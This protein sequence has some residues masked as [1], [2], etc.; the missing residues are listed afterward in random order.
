MDIELLDFLGWIRPPDK[1]VYWKIVFFITHPKHMLW[2]L[3]EHPKHIF[4]SMG[5]KITTILR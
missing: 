2:V 4:K 3:V 1:S 5:K